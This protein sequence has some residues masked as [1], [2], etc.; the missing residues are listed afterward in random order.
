MISAIWRCGSAS[1]QIG[2]VIGLFGREMLVVRSLSEYSVA[3]QPGHIKGILLF[4]NGVG[5]GLSVVAC[6]AVT[7]F[8]FLARHDSP[9]LI[10]AVPLFMITNAAIMLG[11]QFA[12]SL[13][14]ILMGEGN[15]DLF[16]H[17]LVV[18]VLMARW[19]PTAASAQR[20]FSPSPRLRW[21]WA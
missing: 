18:I 11:S 7:A 8:A 21:R 14:C 3:N 13:V 6:R 20:N 4:S 17:L 10:L 12:R 16:W 5:L 19:P 1:P 9:M 2:C 15:R